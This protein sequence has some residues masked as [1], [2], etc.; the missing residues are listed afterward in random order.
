MST[1]RTDHQR[2]TT[3]RAPRRP[4]RTRVGA[5]VTVTV[6]AALLTAGCTS[7]TSADAATPT[8]PTGTVTRP[9]IVAAAPTPEPTVIESV[10]TTTPPDTT[11]PDTTP[12]PPPT[13]PA[14]DAGAQTELVAALPC[15][16]PPVVPAEATTT[17][18]TLIDASGDGTADDVAVAYLD[19]TWRIRLEPS[20]GPISEVT[21]GD[22]GPGYVDVL[23]AVQIDELP[24]DQI[25]A[26]VG[27]GASGVQ[28]GVF[29]VDDHG[30]L[31]RFTHGDGR[32]IDIGVRATIGAQRGVFCAG[33]TLFSYGA[34]AVGD[35]E[36]VAWGVDLRRTGPT[37]LDTGTLDTQP[38]YALEELPTYELDC[39]GLTL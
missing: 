26:V 24:G 23:G 33:N 5:T 37:T 13:D 32:S 36:W 39:S 1:T 29:G 38:G 6:A 18:T 27:S 2:P 20:T 12:P 28:L 17:S 31:F 34:D 4:V 15:G 25:M 19:G 30:C 9:T 14:P 11:P 10:P 7:P 21:I 35:D 16:S 8:T 3:V 22:V